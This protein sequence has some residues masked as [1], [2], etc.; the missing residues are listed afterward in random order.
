VFDTPSP[1]SEVKA[2]TRRFGSRRLCYSFALYL[3]GLALL[4]GAFFAFA[5]RTGEAVVGAL[6]VAG[7][8]ALWLIPYHILPLTL[9]AL[10]W[11]SLLRVRPEHAGTASLPYLWWV[12]SIREAVSSILPV[13]RIGGEVVGVHLIMRRGFSLAFATATV[14]VEVTVTLLSQIALALLGFGL[15]AVFMGRG[16]LL[17]QALPIVALALAIVAVFVLLQHGGLVGFCGRVFRRLT[18]LGSLTGMKD[19]AGNDI[20]G[21]I[22][23]IYRRWR[24]LGGCFAGQIA[25]LLAGSGEVWIA[26]RLM[27]HPVGVL[28]AVILEAGVQALR[29]GGFFVPGALGIQEVGLVFLGGLMGLPADLMLAVSVLKRLRE[30]VYGGLA[31]L[32]W[33]WAEGRRFLVRRH[34]PSVHPS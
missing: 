30:I 22:R 28:N 5:H 4:V 11:R 29:T 21:E 9:D 27:G 14:V 2:V 19:G 10:G 3:L 24:A 17:V 15:L 31:L 12:A 33:Q 25:G 26:L 7:L 20:D 23:A 18:G 8:G 34:A 6:A 1:Q 16:E 32:S 13:V